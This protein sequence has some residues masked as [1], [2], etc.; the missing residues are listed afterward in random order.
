MTEL[1]ADA[2]LRIW[3]EAYTEKFHC[4]S[5]AA[6]TIYKGAGL[7]IDANVDTIYAHTANSLTLVDGDV[8]LGI[9]VEKKVVA[10]GA[11]ETDADSWV[12]AYVGPTIVGF[13]STVFTNVDLGKQVGM[14]DTGTLIAYGTG[15]RNP[16]GTGGAYPR[17]GWLR[18]V[19]DGYA[20][21]QLDTPWVIDVT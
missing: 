4:D 13:K 1:S 14:S 6:Q 10:A 18:R 19:E 16:A 7:V 9:A 17:I 15:V 11:S 2:S 3:G 20:F 12:E 5:A 8:F 21:V